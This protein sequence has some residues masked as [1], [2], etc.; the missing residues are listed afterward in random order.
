MTYKSADDD[1]AGL[2]LTSSA[3]SRLDGRFDGL[4]CLLDTTNRS[5]LDGFAASL[6]LALCLLLAIDD[7]IE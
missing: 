1:L 6:L 5:L 7:G 3:S 2:R 4:S